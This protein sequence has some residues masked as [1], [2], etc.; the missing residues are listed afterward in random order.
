MFTSLQ[1]LRT[2]C[3]HFQYDVSNVPSHTEH[4]KRSL[5]TSKIEKKAKI[6]WFSGFAAITKRKNRKVPLSPRGINIFQNPFNSI[7]VNLNANLIETSK[8]K[9]G[10]GEEN[11]RF[12]CFFFAD[13]VVLRLSQREKIEKSHFLEEEPIF[14]KILPTAFLSTWMQT[15]L[16]PISLNVD[17]VRRNFDFCVFLVLGSFSQI[18]PSR[19]SK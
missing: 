13:L 8:S 15:Y 1:T 19:I 17:L 2:H 7:F 16:R 11:L 10:L 18:L 6:C 3:L 9:R 5:E 14:F 12:L 4:V